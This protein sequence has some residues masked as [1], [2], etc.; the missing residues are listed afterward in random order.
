MMRVDSGPGG[1]DNEFVDT[2]GPILLVHGAY[3]NGG[4]WMD[5]S[6][7]DK[8][9]LPMLL[10]EAGY[11][12]FIANKRGTYYSRKHTKFDADKHEAYWNFSHEEIGK[13]DITTM[14]S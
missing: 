11:D 10:H 12:V 1:I 4:S 9:H 2:K 14:I 13:Y 8:V 3:T 5:R 6:D 7:Q